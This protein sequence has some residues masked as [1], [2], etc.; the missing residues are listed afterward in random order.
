MKEQRYEGDDELRGQR[1]SDSDV[2]EWAEEGKQLDLYVCSECGS[3][4]D[5]TCEDCDF[6]D[7]WHLKVEVVPDDE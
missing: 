7:N 3:I 4:S 1:V 5:S 6:A 2:A